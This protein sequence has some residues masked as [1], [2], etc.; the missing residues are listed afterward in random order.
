MPRGKNA[1]HATRGYRLKQVGRKV[2]LMRGQNTA[3]TFNCECESAGG[4][5]VTISGQ[6]AECLEDGCKGSCGWV[7]RIGG[8]TGIWEARKA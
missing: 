7:I 6:T 5:K 4:C 3:A 8:L 2:A 1:I